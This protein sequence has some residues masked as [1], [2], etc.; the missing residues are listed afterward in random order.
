MKQYKL[1]PG[2]RFSIRWGRSVRVVVTIREVTARK[3]EYSFQGL[4]EKYRQ[5]CGSHF[6]L[7]GH[8]VYTTF[9]RPFQAWLRERKARPVKEQKRRKRTKQR[10]K[11]NIDKIK[12][13][14]DATTL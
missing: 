2:A 4:D 6:C 9:K 3:V 1:E 7:E 10:E 11:R 12:E 13:V 14:N 5:K 8:Q